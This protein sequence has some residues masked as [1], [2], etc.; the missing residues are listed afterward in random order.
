[1]SSPLSPIRYGNAHAAL[2]PNPR[3]LNILMSVADPPALV[4]LCVRSQEGKPGKFELDCEVVPWR[5]VPAG[6]P[7]LELGMY[8]HAFF[9]LDGQSLR[10][11][12]T[13]AVLEIGIEADGRLKTDPKLPFRRCT[14]DELKDLRREL[15]EGFAP[16]SYDAFLAEAQSVEGCEDLKQALALAALIERLVEKVT[17]RQAVVQRCPHCAQLSPVTARACQHCGA[18]R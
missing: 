8:Q 1:M 2:S 4:A 13:R 16:G 7:S 17:E 12:F 6:C 14:D 5:E 11:T 15:T 9:R 18:P 10:L 3:E